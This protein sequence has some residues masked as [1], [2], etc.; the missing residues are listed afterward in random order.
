MSSASTTKDKGHIRIG[1]TGRDILSPKTPNQ[2]QWPTTGKNPQNTEHLSEEWE[3]C[4]LCQTLQPLYT[5]LEKRA[6]KTNRDF[7]KE[8]H[9][10][11]GNEEPLLKRLHE[12]SHILD[13]AQKKQFESA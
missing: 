3:V 12:D 2:A 11:T 13:P 9:R 7:N 4:G 8:N 6:S 5:A 1:R 10:T